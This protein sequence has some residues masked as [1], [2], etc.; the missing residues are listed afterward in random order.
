MIVS[1]K[2]ENKSNKTKNKKSKIQSLKYF[3][4][5]RHREEVIGDLLEMK[6]QLKIDGHGIIWIT[7]IILF[8]CALIMYS[9]FKIKISDFY[10][11]KNEK[12]R[13]I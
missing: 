10:K 13:I 5:A 6:M 12:E 2:S 4:P 11:D 7:L 1:T 3:I 9:M 8:N